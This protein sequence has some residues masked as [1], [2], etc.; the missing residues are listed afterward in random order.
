[1]ARRLSHV[2][3]LLFCFSGSSCWSG[4][5]WPTVHV[6]QNTC[7]V[8][9]QLKDYSYWWN[10]PWVDDVH[11]SLLIYTHWKIINFMYR[12]HKY[13]HVVR[14]SSKKKKSKLGAQWDPWVVYLSSPNS[15]IV[16]HPIC[17]IWQETLVWNYIFTYVASSRS[18]QHAWEKRGNLGSNIM[19][20]KSWHDVMKERRST[21]V[22]FESVHQLQFII[23]GSLNPSGI[24][25]HSLEGFGTISSIQV[26][27]ECLKLWLAHTQFSH[28]ATLD[29]GYVTH[30][31]L[32][33]RLS[34]FSAC[35]IG[36]SLGTRLYTMCFS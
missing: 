13:K 27:L 9:I 28:L 23:H 26:E 25:L 34:R 1:M 19:W 22:D 33:T 36:R 30:M 31:T 4:K 12:T 24:L 14:D 3:S 6:Q 29:T 17:G 8:R 20:Q 16:A 35:N 5:G 2:Q 7:I 15:N 10:C 32:E 11:G 18:F 21:T